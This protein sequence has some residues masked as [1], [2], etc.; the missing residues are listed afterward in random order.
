MYT[1]I[2]AGL[3]TAPHCLQSCWDYV[4]CH[5]SMKSIK[6]ILNYVKKSSVKDVFT[7]EIS[8][9]SYLTESN[10]QTIITKPLNIIYNGQVKGQFLIIASKVPI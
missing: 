2:I 5:N 3:C 6:Y 7:L 8:Q 1:V 9:K 4:E 10:L